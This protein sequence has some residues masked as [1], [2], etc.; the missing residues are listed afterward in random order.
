METVIIIAIVG[1]A[2][3][4]MGRRVYSSLKGEADCGCGCGKNCRSKTRICH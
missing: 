3:F 2:I 1:A 4:F